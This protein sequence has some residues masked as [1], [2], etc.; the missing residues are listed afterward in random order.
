MSTAERI[1][2]RPEI[3]DVLQ[4][5]RTRI[6]RYVLWEGVSLVVALLGVVFW[7]S[8]AIDYGLEPAGGVRTAL[9]F[10]AVLGV[11]AACVW[12][13]VLRLARSLGSRSL[14]LVLERR[15]PQLNDRL[16]TAVEL[17]ENVER[18]S[19]LTASML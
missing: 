6:R 15:F 7:V 14:A 1:M 18:P 10:I 3:P 19:P 11:G 17:A 12:H 16:I 5:L 2:P 8:L 4:Q 13:V 9:L